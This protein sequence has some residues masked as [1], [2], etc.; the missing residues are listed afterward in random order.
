M[1]FKR[2]LTALIL[3][4]LVASPAAMSM[5]AS[6]GVGVEPMS[7]GQCLREDPAN[8]TEHCERLIELAK[9]R[10][11]L[12]A[13]STSSKKNTPPIFIILPSYNF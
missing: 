5:A 11:G 9:W 12:A 6:T 13:G 2:H 1:I 3:A 4:S 8:L 10:E 7:L